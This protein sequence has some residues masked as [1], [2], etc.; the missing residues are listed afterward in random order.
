MA[1]IFQR[2]IE[3]LASIYAS[4]LINT[5]FYEIKKSE[6]KKVKCLETSSFKYYS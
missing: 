6:E 5:D 2:K 3:K 4:S 1:R